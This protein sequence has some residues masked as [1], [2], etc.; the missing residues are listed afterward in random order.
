MAPAERL[1]SRMA[2][3]STTITS[4]SATWRHCM[5]TVLFAVACGACDAPHTVTAPSAPGPSPPVPALRVDALSAAESAAGGAY[6]YRPT[7]TLTAG[8]EAVTVMDLWIELE[9]DRN[10]WGSYL[11]DPRLPYRLPAGA[12][13]RLFDEPSMSIVLDAFRADRIWAIV[14][15][16]DDRGR[17]VRVQ[18]ASVPVSRAAR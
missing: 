6:V 2:T 14:T 7:L 9:D 12:T 10:G 1:V 3:D 5:A 4:T 11:R 8:A 17:S 18:S 15:Y 16:V 13:H